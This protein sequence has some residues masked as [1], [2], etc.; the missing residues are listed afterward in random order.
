MQ[1]NPD[2]FQAIALGKKTFDII[3]VL[4]IS[5]TQIKCEEVLSLLEVDIDYKLINMSAIYINIS[6]ISI[7][8]SAIY[9][10]RQ[11]SSWM[12]WRDLVLSFLSPVDLQYFILSVYL[13]FHFCPLAWHFCTKHNSRKLERIQERALRFTYDD[14]NSSFDELLVKADIPSLHVRKLR[15]MALESLGRASDSMTAL[16]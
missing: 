8:I 13:I 5:D 9:V 7:N 14:F 3:L 11:A 10:G 12:S 16:T 4:K 6:A 2:K 1:A 15:T